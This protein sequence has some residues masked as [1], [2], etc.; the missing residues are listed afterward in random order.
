METLIIRIDTKN[1]ASRIKEAIKQ[2]KGVKKVQEE[3]S[4]SDIE[5]LENR[6]ILKAVKAGRKTAKVDESEIFKALR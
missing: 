1:N 6:S 2:F 4:L 3:L 5:E